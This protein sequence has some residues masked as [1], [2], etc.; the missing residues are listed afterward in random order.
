MP[1]MRRPA[2]ARRQ[3]ALNAAVL[4]RALVFVT[5]L[6]YIAA[7]AYSQPAVLEPTVLAAA[8]NNRAAW[9]SLPR[10]DLFPIIFS[11]AMSDEQFRDWM[12]M[13]RRAFDRLAVE[14]G[15]TATY[16]E[17]FDEEG[18]PYAGNRGRVRL[19]TL[20]KE[21]A[22]SLYVL[23][24]NESYHRVSTLWGAGVGSSA[25]VSEIVKRFVAAVEELGPDYVKWPF[26]LAEAS[27]TVDSI[28]ALRGLPA[29]IGIID[30]THVEI[31]GRRSGRLR[32]E[33][34]ISYNT[35]KRSR[36]LCSASS[37]ARAGSR[38]SRPVSRGR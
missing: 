33:Q 9:G 21:I 34:F 37:T 14:L 29:C 12:R 3:A 30:G 16:S 6:V 26:G 1:A 38:T 8:G 25:S 24:G 5:A 18:L 19:T 31:P 13:S 10:T 4:L 20:R 22:V 7:V 23:S 35:P 27:A 17:I 36:S 32:G 28:E 11:G 2:C 15:R